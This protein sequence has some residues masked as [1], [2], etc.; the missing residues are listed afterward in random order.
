VIA[1]LLALAGAPSLSDFAWTATVPTSPSG[2]LEWV[3]WS[4]SVYLF[5]QRNDLGDVALFS[6]DGVL[7]PWSEP[8]PGGRRIEVADLPLER[9]P[10]APKANGKADTVLVPDRWIAQVPD[11]VRSLWAAG[12]RLEFDSDKS[13]SFL[14]DVVLEASSDLADWNRVGGGGICRVGSGSSAVVRDSVPLRGSLAKYL[15]VS[16]VSNVPLAIGRIRISL[17]RDSLFAAVAPRGSREVDGAVAKDGWEYDLGADFPVDRL[18]LDVPPQSILDAR[19]FA[20]GSRDT[21]W[22]EIVRSS[23]FQVDF[24]GHSLRTP[25]LSLSGAP[26]RH[27][28]VVPVST[29]LSRPPRLKAEWTPRRRIFLSSPGRPVL[30][31]VGSRRLLSADPGLSQD[32]FTAMTSNSGQNLTS[33]E[34]V[35]PSGFRRQGTGQPDRI[36]DRG[37]WVL[38]ALVAAALLTLWFAWK[39]WKESKTSATLEE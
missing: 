33:V 6:E 10:P 9:L 7:L 22:T 38:A 32:I 13:P 3:Q 27:W 19:V 24:Q 14:G 21:N 11:S 31:A 28:R 5:S 1:L 37:K 2:G 23:F 16:V 34:V 26:L 35:S 17:C 4:D 30:L 25:P 8:S 39:V 18:S 36:P 20:R 12:T 15:R 29:T